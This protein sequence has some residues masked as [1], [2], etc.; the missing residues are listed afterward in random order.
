MPST[1]RRRKVGARGKRRVKDAPLVDSSVLRELVLELPNVEDGTTDRGIA[2]KI[3][4]RLLICEATHDSA[5]PSS[6]VVRVSP[7]QRTRLMA[8]YP[9]ALYLPEHY[10]KH[11]AVLARLA[12]LDR[13]SLRDILGTAWL[14]M[15]E[16]ALPKKR[17]SSRRAKP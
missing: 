3:G 9:D 7:E 1:T 5:E 13:E 10:A 2:F 6:F 8:A 11:P 17:R 14:F 15:A 12:R 16:K 4:G